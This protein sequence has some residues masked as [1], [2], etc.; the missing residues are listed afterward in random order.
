MDGKYPK[1]PGSADPD[2]KRTFGKR[3]KF[4]RRG[5]ELGAVPSSARCRSCRSNQAPPLFHIAPLVCLAFPALFGRG[6]PMW[7]PGSVGRDDPARRVV[8]ITPPHPSSPSAMPP[9]PLGGEGFT[10]AFYRL[11]P[12]GGEAVERSETDEGADGRRTGD[13]SPPGEVLSMDGKYPKIPGLRTRTQS[14]RLEKGLN[15]FGA[16]VNLGPF[17]PPPAAARAG[18]IRRPLFSTLRL[19][20][21][22]PFRL[23]LVGA[24]PCGGPGV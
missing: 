12:T 3:S 17:P 8:T 16:G 6:R 22:L 13:V 11:P 9:S 20:Y 19:S 7:R 10:G 4:V 14:A 5:R 23:Y 2:P 1:I 15:L 18:Q 24:A 21:A